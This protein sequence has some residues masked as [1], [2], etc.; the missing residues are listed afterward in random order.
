MN[1]KDSKVYDFLKSI[2]ENEIV[3]GEQHFVRVEINDGGYNSYI[4]LSVDIDD[5]EQNNYVTKSLR[6]FRNSNSYSHI[7]NTWAF[8]LGDAIFSIRDNPDIPLYFSSYGKTIKEVE[9]EV[10]PYFDKL[11]KLI[12]KQT[13]DYKIQAAKSI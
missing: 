4:G 2:A 3:S 11:K 7:E 5:W 12:Q 6:L 1:N 10:I 13:S 8:R 9:D